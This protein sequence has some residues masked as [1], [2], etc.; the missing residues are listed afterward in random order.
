MAGVQALCEN[1]LTIR[2][3]P[4]ASF[5]LTLEPRAL[6]HALGIA[7]YVEGVG[8]EARAFNH[9]LELQT[10]GPTWTAA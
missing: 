4:G 1:H 9:S 8:Q 2:P 3:A 10:A 6:D 5:G 7:L